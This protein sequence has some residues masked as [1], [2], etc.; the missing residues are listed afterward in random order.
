MLN[1]YLLIFLGTLFLSFIIFS[2]GNYLAIGAALAIVFLLG[3]EN[4]GIAFNPAITI[5]LYMANKIDRSDII[6]HI[7]LQIL[8]GIGG[9]ELVRRFIKK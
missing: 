9:Y 1:K 3:G 8:G 2:T 4:S 6:P 7:I 5:P